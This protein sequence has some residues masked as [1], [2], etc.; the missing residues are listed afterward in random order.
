MLWAMWVGNTCPPL[1]APLLST[2][3]SAPARS[4]P[5]AQ[6]TGG[7]VAAVLRG[8]L[9]HLVAEARALPG[10]G[11]ADFDTRIKVRTPWGGVRRRAGLGPWAWEEDEKR[12]GRPG[13]QM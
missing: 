3:H 11:P 9:G 12:M 13:R 8:L 4:P 6:R 2:C 10:S 7:V 5:R 1:A